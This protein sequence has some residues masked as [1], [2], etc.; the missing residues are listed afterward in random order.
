MDYELLAGYLGMDPAKMDSNRWQINKMLKRLRDNYKLVNCA[1][2][3]N[4]PA[5]ITLLDYDDKTGKKFL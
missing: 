3:F 5:E 4:Q 1:V 2:K